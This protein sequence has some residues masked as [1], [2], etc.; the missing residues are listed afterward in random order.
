[1]KTSD[2]MTEGMKQYDQM[3]EEDIVWDNWIIL[4]DNIESKEYDTFLC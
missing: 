1:M 2:S 4:D 3:V